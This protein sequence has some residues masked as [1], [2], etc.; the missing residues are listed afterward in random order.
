MAIK[1]AHILRDYGDEFQAMLESD[2]RLRSVADKAVIDTD[3]GQPSIKTIGS[4]I[5]IVVENVL[6]V[7]INGIGN[8]NC[9]IESLIV[10]YSSKYQYWPYCCSFLLLLLLV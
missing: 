2:E 4:H 7:D 10:I 8:I 1:I 9:I 5:S 3:T 6:G